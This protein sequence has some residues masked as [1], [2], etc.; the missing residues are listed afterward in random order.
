MKSTI[1]FLLLLFVTTFWAQKVPTFNQVPSICIGN[2]LA[3]LPTT[4][5]DGITG[6]WSPDINNQGTYVYTFTP[7]PGQGADNAYMQITADLPTKPSFDEINPICAGDNLYALPTTSKEGINGAWEPALNNMESTTYT[8]TPFEGQCASVTTL[9]ITVNPKIT[10]LF[11]EVDSIC[12]GSYLDALPTTSLEGITGTWSPALDNTKTTTY[13][14]TPHSGQCAESTQLTIVVNA[15]STPTFEVIEPL[16]SENS[17][18]ALSNVSLEGIYG[19]WSPGFDPNN[20]TLYTFTPDGGQCSGTTTITI[21]VIQSEIPAFNEINPICSGEYLEPLPTTSNNGIIGTWSPELDNT[22]T[23]AY[24][25]TPNAGQCASVSTLTIKVDHKIPEFEEVQAICARDYL[26]ELPTTSINGFYGKWSPELDNTVTTTYTFTPDEG[27]CASAVSLT[28]VVHQYEA[29]FEGLSICS[30]MALGDLPASSANGVIGTWSNGG[31]DT[32]VFTP[33]QNQCATKQ[34][35]V[36]AAPNVTPDFSAVAPIEEGALMDGLLPAISI[37]GIT[38]TWSPEPNNLETTTYIFTPNPGQCAE[39]TALTIEVINTLG[40][41]GFDSLLSPAEDL[42]GEI[43]QGT[44]VALA[45]SG[46]GNSNEVGIT[47]G[48]LSVSPSGAANYSIPITV[49]PGINGVVPQIGLAYNSQAGVGMA[50][51][52]WNIAGLSAITRIPSTKFHDGVIDPVDFDL[53]DRF[54]LD[55]QRLMLKSGTY[56]SSGSVYETE[57]FSNT[58]VTF[59]GTYFKVEYPDG[60]TAYYGQTP[61]SKAGITYAISSWENPQAVRV[62]Y[63]YNNTNNIAYINTIKYGSAGSANPINEIKFYYVNRSR[64]EQSYVGGFTF[65]NDKIISYISVKGNNV[66]FRNY[67]LHYDLALNYERLKK[68]TEKNGPASKSYNPTTFEYENEDLS[69]SIVRSVSDNFISDVGYQGGGIAAIDGLLFK[70]PRHMTFYQENLINGDFDGDG[71]QDFVFNGKLFT[72]INDNGYPPLI[73]DF[74]NLVADG[75]SAY[76]PAKNLVQGS[77]GNF[78][79]LNRDAWCYERKFT[80]S[81]GVTKCEY[82][83]YAKDLAINNVTQLYSREVTINTPYDSVEG[84]TGDFNGDGI[85]DRLLIKNN[86]SENLH[87]GELFFINLDIRVPSTAKSLGTISDLTNK[88]SYNSSIHTYKKTHTYIA[89]MN[90]DGR[91]DIVVFKGGSINKIVVYSLDSNDNLVTLWET[92]VAFV[93]NNITTGDKLFYEAIYVGTQPSAFWPGWKSIYESHYYDPIIADLNGDGKSDIILPGLE[94]KV[95]LSSGIYLASEA[96]PNT[97]PPSQEYN[98]F[99]PTDFNND[100]KT[101]IVAI[102]KTGQNSFSVNNLTRISTGNWSSASNTFSNDGNSDCGTTTTDLRPFMIKTSKTYIDRPQVLVMEYRHA[103]YC[104]N[105]FKIG[106]YTNMN[107]MSVNKSLQGITYGNGAKEFIYYGHLTPGSSIYAAA[108]QVENYPNYDINGST[109]LR[110]VEHISKEVKPGAFKYQYYR[111]YGGTGNV[112]GLGF[113]GFRSV[114][115]TNW[116]SDF[117]KVISTVTMADMSLRGAPVLSFSVKGLVPPTKVLLPNDPYISKTVYSYNKNLTENPLQGN[118]VFKLRS[119]HIQNFNELDGTI[120]TVSSTYDTYN[121]KNTKTV[122]Q[123]SNSLENKTIDEVYDYDNLASVPYMIGRPKSKVTTAKLGSDTSITEELYTFNGN[124]LTEV[125]RRSTN[126]GLT[127]DYITETNVYDIYGNITK[128]TLSAPTMVNRVSTLQYDPQTHRFITKKTDILGLATDYTYDMNT[129]LILSEVLPSVPGFP[130][131]TTY[132]YDT[133]GKLAKTTNY[134]GSTP[135]LLLTD[136][137]TNVFGGSQ[138]ATSGNDGSASKIIVDYLG[139][140]IH[141]QVKDINDKWSC[142]STQ[143]DVNNNPLK[144]SKPYFVT[145]DNLGSFPVWDEMQYDLYGRIIQSNSSKSSSSNGKQTTYG[146]SGLSVTE[147]DGQKQKTT[148]KNVYGSVAEISEAGGETIHYSYFANGNL[149]STDTGGAQTIIEQ[150]G[151]GRKITLIDPSAGTHR[152]T[153]NNFGESTSEELEGKGITEYILDDYGRVKERTIKGYGDDT[154]NSTTQY[155]YNALNLS[156]LIL[157]KDLSNDY[158]ISYIYDYDSFSRI[159]Y[160]RE[161]RSETA[162][163]KKFFDFQ[164]GFLYDGFSRLEREKLYAKDMLTNKDLEKWVKTTYKNGSKHQLLDMLSSTAVGNT[165]LWQTNTTNAAGK[166]LTAALG[167]GVNISNLYDNT[168]VPYLMSHQ[169]GSNNVISLFSIFNHTT[170]NLALRHYTL[171]NM[172]WI[173]NLAYD[174]FDRLTTYRDK[175]GYKTQSYNSNGT[176]SDNNIGAYDYT[177]QGQPYTQTSVTPV[178]QSVIDYYSSRQQEIS[179]NAFNSPTSIFENGRERVDFEYNPFNQRAVMYYGDLEKGKADR[180]MRKFY[181]ADGSMEIRR[182]TT[183]GGTVNEFIFYIGGDGYTAPIMYRSIHSTKDY[184]YLHRDYQGSIIAIT[185]SAGNVVEKRFYDAWGTIVAYS[186][187]TNKIPT[188]S[189][190]MFLDRG[191]TGHEH[192]LGVGLINMNGR[193]YDPKLHRFLQPDNNIQDPTN[194][195]NFNRFGYCMNN[196]TKYSDPSGEIW[197]FVAG[198]LF[199]AYVHGAQA[200][201]EANPLKWNAGEFANAFAAPASQVISIGATSYANNYIDNYNKEKELSTTNTQSNEKYPY[202]SKGKPSFGNTYNHKGKSGGY[203]QAYYDEYDGEYFGSSFEWRSFAGEAYES[204]GEGEYNTAIDVGVKG[205]LSSGAVDLRLGTKDNNLYGEAKGRLFAAEANLSAGYF[206]GERDLHG[207]HLD[208]NA[209]YYTAEGDLTGGFTLFGVQFGYTVGASVESYHAG[210]TGGLW[211][212]SSEKKLHIEGLQHLGWIVGEK[213]GAKLVIPCFFCD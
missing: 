49:P 70:T 130:V 40:S 80:D 164:R 140:K 120:S 34:V 117:Q 162:V 50:G 112:E 66:P 133:W 9:T 33:D 155:W 191:Y 156:D 122:L 91:S 160:K 166:V 178:D 150:D 29:D 86:S 64:K 151:F 55:G 71:D 97:F 88:V 113:L 115:K 142:I 60:S 204:F 18:N 75:I 54:A 199:S 74:S 96:L 144:I 17:V 15:I 2:P 173:E 67:S 46:T 157:F 148:V 145:G 48:Q 143:Y 189:T 170:G 202:L 139:R 211:Y 185:G 134:L 62:L 210:I 213:F 172:A 35:V 114:I 103:D 106:F 98:S 5:L 47:A 92:P 108:G 79:L 20:T 209:G 159:R 84:L 123:G 89:D 39:S 81:P 28:I 180:S 95:L 6:V 184:Y 65:I 161:V 125:K 93:H 128:K 121:L 203:L 83:F 12:I 23:T 190:E 99:L 111:Y 212:D 197:G 137:Y 51:Y 41:A 21:E 186:G 100:G 104:F 174:N 110:A 175:T 154:T 27:Q 196:P 10:P 61:D 8:F 168:G 136:A 153:Y 43:N 36:Q 208:A 56:G 193:I 24:T 181:S 149:K 141:E 37:N 147:N 13:T 58:K 14:F 1:T 116:F 163:S 19:T 126:S 167:N 45:G 176:I 68:V 85:T 42:S 119:T 188:T 205:A 165:K 152:Y 26:H 101:D 3:P 77:D 94:R 25:F 76:F 59:T 105:E 158:F 30:G 4:S 109:T 102:R 129:G 57:Q 11:S 198:F 192:M 22:I 38:G 135:V 124:L 32:F 200:T 118:K 127:T 194:P 171:P 183:S 78:K 195:Q 131:K 31:G 207:L 179:Y 63:N 69:T 87:S 138:K 132:G 73:T 53:Y 72:K 52:G 177:L 206:S 44:V 16:C 169:K 7:N 82:S 107:V 182:R 201:G 90:G 146:Y 187:T